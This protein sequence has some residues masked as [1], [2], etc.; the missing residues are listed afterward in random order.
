LLENGTPIAWTIDV[1]PE[2]PHFAAAQLLVVA[3]AIAPGSE[4]AGRLELHL[5]SPLTPEESTALARALTTLITD[6]RLSDISPTPETPPNWADA[7]DTLDKI[8]TRIC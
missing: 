8:L 3:G 7:C 2:H 6:L 1:P 4:R 5:N